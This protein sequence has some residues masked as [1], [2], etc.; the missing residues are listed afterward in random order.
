MVDA[1]DNDPRCGSYRARS[2][3]IVLTFAPN[4]TN[5]T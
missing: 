2:V 1:H 3:T 5:V 4:S